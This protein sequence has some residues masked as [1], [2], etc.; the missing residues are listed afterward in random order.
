MNEGPTFKQAHPAA[1]KL[2]DEDFYY[3]PIE[4]SGPFG[5]DDAS[6]TFS[7]FQKW[8]V[9]HPTNDPLAFLEEQFHSWGYPPF[10]LHVAEPE[11]ILDYCHAYELGSTFLTGMDAAIVAVAFGQLYLEGNI[12]TSV[13]ALAITS[14]QRQLSPYLL[15]LWDIEYQPVRLEQLNKILMVLNRV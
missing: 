12:D 11:I 14:I 1:Q 4:E 3:S 6:D 13:Q 9:D 8:R 10:D 5:S 2:M 15:Q 7:G